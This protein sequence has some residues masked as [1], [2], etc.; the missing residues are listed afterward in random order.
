V[1]YIKEKKVFA[2]GLPSLLLIF[3]INHVFDYTRQQAFKRD[4]ARE[5]QVVVRVDDST[6][7]HTSIGIDESAS[8]SAGPSF[9]QF[10]T[11]ANWQ[12]DPNT[13]PPCPSSVRQFN[14]RNVNCVG[15]M[16]PLTA[17]PMV[18]TFCLLRTTQ[19]CCYGPRPQYNQ[20][21]LV[22]AK[23]PVKFER[24]APVMVSGRFL[25]DP[26]PDQGFIYRM[27][28][29][30]VQRIGDEAPQVNAAQAAR[31]ANVPLFSFSLLAG[32]KP[33]D[34]VPA[35]LATELLALEGKQVVVEGFI[36]KR[37]PGQVPSLLI[38][39]DFWDGAS[40]GKRPT[41]YNAMFV[42]PQDPSQVPPLW[43]QHNVFTGVL[44]ITRDSRLWQ[45]DGIVSLHSARMGIDSKVRMVVNLGPLV[46][47]SDEAMIFVLFLFYTIRWRRKGAA[48][49]TAERQ[50]GK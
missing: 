37:L 22:E 29:A 3:S 19:T 48:P 15:F 24:L 14:G 42:Y 16:Y 8:A 27:D 32:M 17:G 7:G 10:A 47:V 31:K 38:S 23:D 12:Y 41:L 2:Y 34:S 30:T 33:S 35:P 28:E 44:K 49:I 13:A 11:L 26:Q 40:Q 9:L 50:G 39:Q 4:K 20:Y 6:L 5:A 36:V 43:Q 45:R 18:K 1:L 46:P 21:I 25:V